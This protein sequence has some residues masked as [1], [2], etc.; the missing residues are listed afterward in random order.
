MSQEIDAEKAHTVSHS[1][2]AVAFE[3]GLFVTLPDSEISYNSAWCH[4]KSGKEL[5]RET[6]SAF[7]WVQVPDTVMRLKALPAD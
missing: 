5:W 1:R 3:S 4:T 7:P 2:L 6:R